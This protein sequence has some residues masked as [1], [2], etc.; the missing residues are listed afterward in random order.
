MRILQAS[1]FWF[2]LGGVE[3]YISGVAG[4]LRRRGHA[5]AEFGMAHEQNG[6][7]DYADLFVPF[8]ELGGA[9]RGLS[10]AA[11]VKTS[12]RILYDARVSRSVGRLCDRF[13]PDVAHVH[14]FERQL[15]PALI[16][17][18]AR[19]GV[20][21]LQTFHDYSF[22]CPSYT[23]MK[24]MTVPCDVE[25][26]RRG[27][28]RA[29]VHRC[30]KGSRAASALSAL[31]LFLRRDVIRYQKR[32]DLF[33]SPSE[34]LRTLLVRWGLEA[35]KVVHLP[36]YVRTAEFEPRFEPGG[37]ALF[38]GRLSFEKGLWTLLDAA[39]G[40]PEVEF[41]IVGRGPEGEALQADVS[42]R[43]L[44]NVR[45]E[46]FKH[47]EELREIYRNALCVVMPSEWPENSPMVVYE[48]FASGKPVVGTAIGGIPELIQPGV[49]GLVVPAFDAA[50]LGEAVRRLANTPGL[51][52]EMGR[53]GREK[54][55]E[56]YDISRHVDRLTTLY[57]G[58][59]E[60]TSPRDPPARAGREPRTAR[61]V[62]NPEDR[63][64]ET[65]HLS[66]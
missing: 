45:L 56:R 31:E 17:G 54:V 9:G 40:L 50:A 14:L 63:L 66:S 2:P 46:G 11:K 25:C 32:V 6:P 38:V 1:K 60:R 27:Y 42:R 21:I 33:I 4:E 49:D 35:R 59:I 20:P 36:N 23:L 5:L 52:R 58:V 10:L 44:A 7:S 41:R 47:G 51:A 3:S 15:T 65:C 37:Y 18:L 22:I 28:H 57:E 34:Y 62:E 26:M 53:R 55:V 43:R 24:G 30:V 16:L 64:H 13:A 39:A 8:V 19:R 29:V 48:A 61:S 12:A